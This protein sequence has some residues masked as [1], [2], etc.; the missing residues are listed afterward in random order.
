MLYYTALMSYV[1]LEPSLASRPP[2]PGASMPLPFTTH[3]PFN[4][5]LPR[6]LSQPAMRY[7]YILCN[8]N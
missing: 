5:P 1:F 7:D 4:V 6:R 2:P 8:V 3:T